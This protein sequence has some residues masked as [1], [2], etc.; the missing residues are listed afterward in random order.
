MKQEAEVRGSS[1]TAT[2]STFSSAN[3]RQFIFFRTF[4][5]LRIYDLCLFC[6]RVCG[7]AYVHLCFSFF[8]NTS[9]T[10]HIFH[11][12][13]LYGRAFLF[14]RKPHICDPCDGGDAFR[15]DHIQKRKKGLQTLRTEY[16]DFS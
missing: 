8:L 7:C 5:T 11:T 15:C 9:R 2:P 6:D 10:F 13:G 3:L 14:L 12:Y 1:E 16:L 4:H